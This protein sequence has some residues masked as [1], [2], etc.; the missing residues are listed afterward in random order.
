MENKWLGVLILLS[1]I[2]NLGYVFFKSDRLEL[3]LALTVAITVIICLSK[4]KGTN[5]IIGIGLFSVGGLLL[6][7]NNAS[8]AMWCQALLKNSSMLTILIIVPMIGMVFHHPHYVA[9]IERVIEK[10]LNSKNKL[11]L[12]LF[13]ITHIL[14]I[15]LNFASITIVG[16]FISEDMAPSSERQRTALMAIARGYT[17]ILMWS[18]STGT[19]A[20]VLQWGAHWHEIFVPGI[21]FVVIALF[22]GWILERV[23]LRN[24]EYSSNDIVTDFSGWQKDSVAPT[25]PRLSVLIGI[26]ALLLI[27]VM[28][29]DVFTKYK[30][31]NSISLVAIFFPF[32]WFVFQNRIGEYVKEA[33]K[34]TIGLSRVTN[35]LVIFVA[36]GFFATAVS[37]S[38]FSAII[39][40]LFAGTENDPIL[41][42]TIMAALIICLAIVG[43]H[44]VLTVTSLNAA[45][46]PAAYGFSPAFISLAAV[47][48]WGLALTCSPVSICSLRVASL[49]NKAP[50]TVSLKWNYIYIVT[51]LAV[52]TLMLYYLV[53]YF[54][55]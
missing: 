45:I 42:A 48:W 31:L 46:N 55:Y 33:V 50:L 52:Y 13:S 10:N 25:V 2:L 53:R 27:L 15:P 35:E 21:G 30:V 41:F 49:A 12:S 36:A 6:V 39:P 38:Q 3:G 34:Y 16:R 54:G 37:Y 5:K 24:T 4:I 7:W 20:L 28:V 8:P 51:L 9:T 29:L 47:T 26:L 14:S 17:S 44:P 32:L 18:P 11:Y 19:M 40:L 1:G 43:V 22:V 23:R